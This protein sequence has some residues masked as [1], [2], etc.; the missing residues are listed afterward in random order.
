MK[1]FIDF[2]RKFLLVFFPFFGVGCFFYF[3]FELI[4]QGTAFLVWVRPLG[5]PLEGEYL[6]YMVACGA[7][8]MTTMGFGL[9]FFAVYSLIRSLRYASLSCKSSA[10]ADVNKKEC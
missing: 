3:A 7:G 6:N 10:E 4:M 2:C 5:T 9:L 1:K 8:A